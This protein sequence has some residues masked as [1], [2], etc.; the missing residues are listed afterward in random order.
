MI[1]PLLSAMALPEQRYASVRQSY[2]APIQRNR[3][4]QAL[5]VAPPGYNIT[6]T[7]N[8]LVSQ[9]GQNSTAPYQ[10]Q[11]TDGMASQAYAPPGADGVT[12]QGTAGGYDPYSTQQAT[13]PQQGYAE[14]GGF[15]TNTGT[16]TGPAGQQ[17]PMEL[18]PFRAQ[19]GG[20]RPNPANPDT[21]LAVQR[22]VTRVFGPGAEIIG[23]SG[24]G[25]HG[26]PRHRASSPAARAAG[27]DTGYALDLQ[28]KLPDG[29]L[30]RTDSPEA[31]EFVM[32]AAA[33]G[34]TGLGA[35]AG[36]GDYMGAHGFHM[37]MYPLEYMG[38]GMGRAWATMGN[39]LEQDF[40]NAYQPFRR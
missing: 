10:V 12:G 9:F 28:V 7:Q 22:A 17:V 6:P 15:P 11:A 40:V 19:Y 3:I 26:S 16:V 4:M 5:G 33:E 8:G 32:A 38:P 31:R 23:T 29:S 1:N 27:I 35:G 20:A 2:V 30:L 13:A 24:T 34:I 14:N 36:H 18:A 37:D 39:R 25:E 21:I